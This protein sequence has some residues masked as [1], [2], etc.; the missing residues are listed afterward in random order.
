VQR[1]DRQRLPSE[2][3]G[4]TGPELLRLIT[5]GGAYDPETGYEQNLVVTAVPV[6]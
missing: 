2:L 1:F 5:C 3:F 6:P 4:R